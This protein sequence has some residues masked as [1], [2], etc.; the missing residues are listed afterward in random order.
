MKKLKH[1][2]HISGIIEVLT[3]MHIGGSEVELDIGGIDNEVVK[4]RQGENRVPYIPGSSLK[5][6]LRALLGRIFGRDKPENDT[7]IVLKLF[8]KAPKGNPYSKNY[9]PMILSQL[10]VRD[11]Y[12][13]GNIET[14]EKAENT[15][16]RVTGD[17]NPRHLE[18]VTKGSQFNLDMILDIYE[19]DNEKELLKTLKLGFD[20]LKNDYLGGNGTRGYGK[21]DIKNLKKTYITFKQDGKVEQSGPKDFNNDTTK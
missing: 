3:G 20:I 5:G 13:I 15:I 9:S 1:K 14:E 16:N 17:A 12:G 7:G 19:N 8:G 6:K 21:I 11:C 2:I 4:I 18:R 10:Q